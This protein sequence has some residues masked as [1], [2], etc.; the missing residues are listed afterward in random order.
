MRRNLGIKLIA[1]GTIIG[2]NVSAYPISHVHA[3]ETT[4]LENS[5]EL[6]SVKIDE[7]QLDQAFSPDVKRYS[8]SVGNEIK[9]MNILVEKKRKQL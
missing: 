4:I 6:Q 8:A 5:A 2:A 1:A 9:T 3:E 7:F